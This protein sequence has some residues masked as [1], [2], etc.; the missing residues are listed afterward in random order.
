ML[1]EEIEIGPK[2]DQ[3]IDQKYGHSGGSHKRVQCFLD[4]LARQKPSAKVSAR[5]DFLNHTFFE[6]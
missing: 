4:A 6:K 2:S 5:A 3:K 1:L